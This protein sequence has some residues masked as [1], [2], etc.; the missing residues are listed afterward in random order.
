[1]L[2]LKPLLLAL[3]L[4]SVSLSVCAQLLL[5]RA[6]S[7]SRIQAA[8]NGDLSAAVFAVALDI[9]VVAGLLIYS[10]S[11]VLWLLVLSKIEVSKAYPFVGLGFVGTMVFACWFLNEPLTL[12][13]VA[14]TVLV[15]CGVA[16][17]ASGS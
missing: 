15:L 9:Y 12:V 13:K 11:V 5:R 7:S 8:L 16:L 14:G 4:S 2:F 1:M 10:L 17:I 3:I 6:M